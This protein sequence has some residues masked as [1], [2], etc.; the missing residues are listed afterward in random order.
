MNQKKI[1]LEWLFCS[2]L[3]LNVY[4]EMTLLCFCQRLNVYM[5]MFFTV[6]YLSHDVC[7][8]H[9]SLICIVHL[10]TYV[11]GSP[12]RQPMHLSGANWICNKPI[13][14]YILIC[15]IYCSGCI[16]LYLF[17]LYLFIYIYIFLLQ[18]SKNWLHIFQN[19][20][21]IVWHRINLRYVPSLST[22][23]LY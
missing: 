16:Q 9:T 4:P 23:K 17:L 15:Y 14:T 5:Y 21:G 12:K 2:R 20:S 6:Q 1:G 18:G 19:V 3:T 8:I 10:C 22:R 7:H 13:S 11:H